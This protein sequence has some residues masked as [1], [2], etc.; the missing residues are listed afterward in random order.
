MNSVS[1]SKKIKNKK[2]QSKKKLLC[3]AIFSLLLICSCKRETNCGDLSDVITNYNISGEDKA[4]I[5][6][7]GSDTLI[8]ISDVNDTAI[9]IG[10]GK[11][12]YYTKERN[13]LSSGDCPRMGEDNFENFAINFNGPNA[14]L[15]I[16]KYVFYM[17]KDKRGGVYIT[18]NNN[19]YPESI[20]FLNNPYYYT[21]STLIENKYYKGCIINSTNKFT[22]LYN[23]QF[24]FL[25]IFVN[26]KTFKIKL[27]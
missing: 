8:F 6:Y 26:N 12:I 15:S 19:T 7:T 5:P 11:N 21:D 25:S 20:N 16:L 4:K 24:G 2:T 13:S 10:Q 22:T 14:D 1:I 17:T 23:Y 9:L 27:K 18:I 3:L